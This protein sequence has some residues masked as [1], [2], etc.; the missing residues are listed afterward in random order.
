M[1]HQSSFTVALNRVR[2][3]GGNWLSL[4]TNCDVVTWYMAWRNRYHQWPRRRQ[5]LGHVAELVNLDQRTGARDH[6]HGPSPIFSPPTFIHA[7]LTVFFSGGCE[8]RRGIGSEVHCASDLFQTLYLL[9]TC[10]WMLWIKNK[11]TQLLI[12]RDLH[13]PKH[14]FPKGIMIIRQRS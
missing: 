4:T 10:S 7:E 1:S 13:L 6:I 5:P 3:W 12:I 2:S 14:Y 11:A 9:V 8:S